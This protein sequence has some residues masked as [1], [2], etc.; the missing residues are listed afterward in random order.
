LERRDGDHAMTRVTTKLE[1][2]Q[3]SSERCWQLFDDWIDPI[4]TNI[5]GRI[6]TFI[7]EMIREEL[8]A[9]LSRP[10]YGRRPADGEEGATAGAAG[11]RHGSR[12]RTLIGTFGKTEIAVP[13]A[14]LAAAD[15]KTAE[16]KSKVLRAYQRRTLAADALI[17]GTYLSGTNTRRV[18]R[19]LRTLFDG[20]VSKDTVSRVWRKV[21]SDWD[22]WNARSL[23]DEPIVRL[24]LDGT[25]VKV[26]LDRKATSISLLVVMGVR[27]D[28]QKMLLAVKSMGGE[29]AAA[30]RSVLDDL[31]R[32]GLRQPELLIVDGGSGLDAALA[33]VWNDV[34]VQR[35]TVH[36]HR[37]LLAHAPE[38]LHEEITADY[39]DMIYAATRQQIEARRKVFI[40]KWRIKH[41]AVA[42]SLEEAGERLFTFTRLPLSQWRSV[43]TTN[44]IER[45]HE[46]FKRRIKTQTVL[47]SADTAA[48]LFWAL[49]ASG[50]I[51][52]RK[53]DG[54]QT[55]ATKPIDQPIDL[56]A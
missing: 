13:R 34:P 38:R 6:R 29:S 42:D 19:A 10:R 24:I 27:A 35:C 16:W 11:H 43:R 21:K 12:T 5:R 49:L 15:G 41:R 30:W 22:A 36:K 25:A 48:M 1:N 8:D 56:A 4:E 50:Q 40:R 54:W 47:P 7:E 46:E 53:V 33:A 9:V 17:A 2:S 3:P 26:R 51:N 39:N 14:R 28:G 31:I 20:A 52:M 37:N 32:R 55:L 45:L 44:A 23:A 18:R